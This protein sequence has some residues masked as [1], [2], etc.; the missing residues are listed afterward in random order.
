MSYQ[1]HNE[2]C[3]SWMRKQPSES[4][5]IILTSPPYNFDMPYGTYKDDITD[6]RSWTQ[7]WI[8]EAS[9]ILKDRGRFIINI[10]PKF[11]HKEPYHHWV[12]QSAE[13]AGL[14][15]YGERIWQKNA[16]NNYRGAA[17]SMGIP[18]KI[19]LWYSTEY[20]QFFAKGDV[21]RPTKKTDSI[22]TIEEQVDYARHHIWSIAPARQRDHPA[23]MPKELALRCLKL[24]AR[25]GDVVYDPFAGAGTTMLAAKELGLDSIGTELD[26]D[27]VNLIHKR[28]T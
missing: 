16:I 5:D 25:K 1:L 6:Y 13:T 27:Y 10:Q 3:I 23:Q 8:T 26:N 9:R 20:V 17:G 7:V 24:F 19:Y 12:H 4:V 11:S 15:W 21:Y 28:M 18:S 2:E 14:L 22:I